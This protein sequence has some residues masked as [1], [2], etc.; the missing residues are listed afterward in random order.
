MILFRLDA[1]LSS[2]IWWCRR[3]SFQGRMRLSR[4]YSSR[5]ILETR[6]FIWYTALAAPNKLQKLFR[7]RYFMKFRHGF[8]QVLYHT[9]HP[10]RN[11]A[12]HW[13]LATLSIVTFPAPL[14]LCVSALKPPTPN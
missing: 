4:S 10:R 14:P 9:P 1:Q 8:V 11:A 2:A 13:A 12:K 5:T 6:L 7:R 3:Y